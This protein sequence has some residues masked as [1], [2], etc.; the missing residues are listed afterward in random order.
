MTKYYLS[1][2][3]DNVGICI[4]SDIGYHH[5]FK[6]GDIISVEYDIKGI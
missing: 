5:Q 3:K 1:V 4:D 6:V 2:L